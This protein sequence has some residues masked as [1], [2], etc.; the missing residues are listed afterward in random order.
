MKGGQQALWQLPGH[1]QGDHER[2]GGQGHHPAG[3]GQGPLQDA[4]V[5]DGGQHHPPAETRQRPMHRQGQRRDEP[6]QQAP[7]TG[8]DR[9]A[10]QHDDCQQQPC[11][12]RQ[13]THGAVG[14]QQGHQHQRSGDQGGGFVPPAVA[15]GADR[16]PRPDPKPGRPAAAIRGGIHGAVQDSGAVQDYGAAQ[17][18]GQGGQHQH[19]DHQRGQQGEDHRDGQVPDNFPRDPL[20]EGHGQEHRDGG[21]R[22]GGDGPAHLPQPLQGGPRGG[23]PLLPQAVNGLQHH[24]RIVH[25]HPDS[26]GQAPHGNQVQGGAPE[27]HGEEGGQDR[28]GNGHHHQSRGAQAAQEKEQHPHRQRAAQQGRAAHLRQRGL[29]KPR[30]VMHQPGL[31]AGRQHLPEGA[32]NFRLGRAPPEPVSPSPSAPHPPFGPGFRPLPF[33]EPGGFARWCFARWR[34]PEEMAHGFG[35]LHHVG[36]RFLEH[37]DF[38]RRPAAG[39]GVYLLAARFEA[40]G[41]HI[42]QPHEGTARGRKGDGPNLLQPG[43]LV[44]RPHTV[45]QPSLVQRPAGQ[46]DVFLAQSFGH[47]GHGEAMAAQLLFVQRDNHLQGRASPH[48]DRRHA[49]QGGQAG[50]QLVGGQSPQGL[51][52]RPPR[53]VFSRG[54][55]A[56]QCQPQDRF[57]VRVEA[58]HLRGFHPFGQEQPVHF[59]PHF[60]RRETQVG[61]P[62]ELQHH[63]GD[64]RPRPR[65][66]R[67]EAGDDAELFFQR[68]GHELLHLFGRAARKRGSHG[69]GGMGKAGHQGQLKP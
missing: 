28:Q 65:P 52:G 3:A 14:E 69:Q 40:D 27:E 44:Q 18:S 56:Q 26:Q 68:E 29:D 10:Q 15:H 46:V 17:D 50:L 5:E 21:E 4:P 47:P 22:G 36:V 37:L 41:G 66:H 61:A 2:Q 51:Q 60:Q 19:R 24:D 55:A 6:A 8:P 32:T 39:Q 42:P 63:L 30:L 67:I 7:A 43:Q 57:V 54:C 64:S 53:G 20:H 58:Q 9:H 45:F 12:E 49:V 11:A 35:H 38:H 25:Q 62:L 13:E 1:G 31:H 48:G 16:F 59:F 23:Q 33:F 34:P